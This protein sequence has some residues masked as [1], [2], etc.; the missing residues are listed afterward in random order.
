VKVH[1][2]GALDSH[3]SQVLEIREKMEPID[4]FRI[5]DTDGK[6]LD[7][8]LEP[9]VN[10]GEFFCCCW[11]GGKKL[12]LLGF[13]QY[14]TVVGKI[15]KWKESIVWSEQQPFASDADNSLT[16]SLAISTLGH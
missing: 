16:R 5:M 9:E 7:P 2:P 10:R 6:V 15:A 1:F 3:F 4:T 12:I 13:Y 11:L 8:S 14:G